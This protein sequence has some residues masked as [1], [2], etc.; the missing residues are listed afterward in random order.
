[1]CEERRERARPESTCNIAI[2]IHTVNMAAALDTNLIKLKSEQHP[3]TPDFTYAYGTA[4]FRNSSV[5]D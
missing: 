2:S 3:K 5:S 1:M 4:G